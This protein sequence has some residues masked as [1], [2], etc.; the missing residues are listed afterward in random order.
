MSENAIEKPTGPAFAAII[1]AAFAAA[2]LGLLATLAEAF[3]GFGDWLSFSER[4][5]MLSGETIV[6]IAVY[7]ASWAGLAFVWRRSNPPLRL[8]AIITAVLL[9]AGLLG[10]FPLFFRIFGVEE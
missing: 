8:V 6:A 2:T 5:G 3:D 4:V 9:A 1:A 7:F 10:T